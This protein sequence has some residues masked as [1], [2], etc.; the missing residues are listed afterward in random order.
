[1][2]T[3]K[4]VI[5]YVLILNMYQRVATYCANF[6]DGQI[7]GFC[8]IL[9]FNP[10]LL[11][12]FIANKPDVKIQENIIVEFNLQVFS[13]VYSLPGHF[14]NILIYHIIFRYNSIFYYVEFV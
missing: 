11:N 3:L 7:R 10:E 13:K 9:K 14:I 6:D 2:T 5:G 1:M 8:A 4:K 12:D